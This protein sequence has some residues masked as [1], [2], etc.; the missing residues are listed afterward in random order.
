MSPGNLAE[1]LGRERG[2]EQVVGGFGSNFAAGFSIAD[3]LADGGQSRP[4]VQLL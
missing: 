3:N 1:T 2:A 4:C